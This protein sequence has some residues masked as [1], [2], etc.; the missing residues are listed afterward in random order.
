MRTFRRRQC[1]TIPYLTMP[2]HN[3]PY[4]SVPGKMS[5]STTQSVSLGA[6]LES[7][8]YHCTYFSIFISQYTLSASSYLISIVANHRQ[9]ADPFAVQPEVLSERLCEDKAVSVINEATDGP[10]I[11]LRIAGGEA[12]RATIGP[13][14]HRHKG[15]GVVLLIVHKHSSMPYPPRSIIYSGTRR[16]RDLIKQSCFAVFV[17]WSDL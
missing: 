5:V 6:T 13:A 15:A 3:L 14:T 10:G 12:L 4:R 2:H 8:L 7:S 9:R 1:Y 11:L 17:F 16:N